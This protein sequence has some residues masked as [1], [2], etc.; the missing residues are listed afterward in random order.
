MDSTEAYNGQKLWDTSKPSELVVEVAKLKGSGTALDLGAGKG[1]DSLYLARQGFK[2]T[3][4]EI[5]ENH[6]VSLNN[7]NLELGNKIKIINSDINYFKPN[8]KFD[9]IICGMVLHFLSS[10]NVISMIK[11]M[12]LWTKPGGYNVITGYSDKN[13][14]GKRPYLFK[15]TE[16]SSYYDDWR[17]IS[18]QEKLTTWFIKPGETDPRRNHAVYLLAQK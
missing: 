8:E 9:I 1:R 4:V 14:V 12:K 17:I 3:A 18:Y 2:V 15:H 7:K 13:E 5:D 11:K 16:L 6:L 10:E